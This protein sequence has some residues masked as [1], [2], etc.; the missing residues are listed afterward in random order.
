MDELI[1]AGYVVREQDREDGLFAG[2]TYHFSDCKDDLIDTDINT[3]FPENQ[4]PVFQE[5]DKKEPL[6]EK[7]EPDF[8]NPFPENPQL[9]NTVMLYKEN[10]TVNSNINKQMLNN[11]EK[12]EKEKAAPMR[13]TMAGALSYVEQK[14]SAEHNRKVDIEYYYQAILDWSDS[15]EKRNRKNRRT[16]RGWVATI[17]MVMRR[18]AD[19]GK[20]KMIGRNDMSQALE[21]L[22]M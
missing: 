14:L 5:S 8:F 16:A 20:V 10:S 15:M 19:A 18:D 12:P 21:Y 22:K 4:K 9:L 11:K 2:Y 3:P 1:Q 13:E 6:P 7:Q 17:R